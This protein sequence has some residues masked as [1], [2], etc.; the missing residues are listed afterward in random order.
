MAKI[1]K[2]VKFMNFLRDNKLKFLQKVALGRLKK[3]HSNKLC[4]GSKKKSM[5]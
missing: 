1:K 3:T 2:Q 4:P 5:Q